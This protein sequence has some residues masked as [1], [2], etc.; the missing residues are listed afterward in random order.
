MESV[1][2]TILGQRYVV[3]GQTS[4][5]HIRRLA[6]YVDARIKDIYR[7]SPGTTPL[8]ASILTALVLSDELLSL[9]KDHES[10]QKR[11]ETLEIG[12]ESILKMI[13]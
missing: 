6:E 13:D 1:E 3:R 7:Q 11:M 12:T 5:A 2:V 8:K 4:K 10:A 9:K